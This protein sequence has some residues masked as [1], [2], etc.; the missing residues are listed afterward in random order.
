MYAT[1]TLQLAGAANLDFLMPIPRYFI[2]A[3]LLAWLLT[4]VGLLKKIF[5]FFHDP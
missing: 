1:C 2:F 3:A 4:F 5:Q